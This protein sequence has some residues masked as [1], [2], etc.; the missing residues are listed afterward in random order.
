MK[1]KPAKRVGGWPE[2]QLHVIK[3]KYKQTP[4]LLKVLSPT[5]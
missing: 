4:N 2:V 1:R 3:Q 5:S